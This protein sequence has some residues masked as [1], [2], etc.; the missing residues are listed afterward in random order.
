MRLCFLLNFIVFYDIIGKRTDEMVTDWLETLNIPVITIDG[1]K[2]IKENIE[3]IL[4][5]LR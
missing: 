2:P 3:L 1:R 5:L 4:G